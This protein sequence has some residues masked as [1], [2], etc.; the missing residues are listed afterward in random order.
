MQQIRIDV[1]PIIFPIAIVEPEPEKRPENGVELA[2]R[3]IVAF[4]IAEG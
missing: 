3:Q 4:T 2:F 1:P